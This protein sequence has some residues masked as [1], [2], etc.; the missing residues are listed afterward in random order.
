MSRPFFKSGIGDLEEAFDR[1]RND[2]EFLLKLIDELSHR[3][4]DRAARLKA[5]AVQALGTLRQFS[6][7][8]N[9]PEGQANAR[10]SAA[11]VLPEVPPL[12]AA[13]KIEHAAAVR[14]PMPPISNS[15]DAVLSA[16]TALEVLSPPSFRRP[17][18]L[19][20]GHKRA[21]AW[22]DGRRV[23]WE[24]N[25]EKARPRTRL[26][27]QI[28]LGTAK[29]EA[30]VARLMAV[31]GDTRIERHNAR[32]EAILALI[33]VD[34]EGRPIE[35]P[36]VALS[37]FGWAVP[38]ALAGD[39]DALGAW[40]AAEKPLVEGLDQLIRQ[41]DLNGDLRPL[42]AASIHNAY[43]WL[44]STL[45]LPADVVKPPAFAI[46]TYEY[47]RNPEPPEPLLLNSFFL[48]DLAM[49]AHH[50]RQDM[51]TANLRR[52]LGV[53]RPE[54]R[55][56]L[57]HDG[58]ALASAIRPILFS[59]A[60]WPG[61]RRHQLVLLQQAAVNLALQ[62]PQQSGILAV[63]GPPGTGKT[64][65]L[66]D[67]VA[68]LVTERARVM[69]GFDDPENAFTN[70][71]ERLRA[72]NAWIHL[73]K[74]DDRLRGFEILVASSNNK[75][76]ENVSAE[77]PG[78]SAIAEDATNLRYFTTLSDAL[79]EKETW[80]LI[81][82]V[83]GNATNRNHFKQTFW[84]HD[85][86][87]LWTY[88]A[89]AAGN[90]RTVEVTN[91]VTKE[92]TTRPPRIVTE[93]RAP[94]NHEDALRRWR[95]ARKSFTSALHR[96]EAALR[97]LESVRALAERLSGLAASEGQARDRL[98]AAVA[99]KAQATAL[100]RDAGQN[101]ASAR[102]RRDAAAADHKRHM[103]ERPGW[104]ARLFRTA[105]FRTWREADVAKYA[106]MQQ[107]TEAL[108]RA[109]TL[110]ADANK[111][112]EQAASA[113]AKAT[114]ELETASEQLSEAARVVGAAREKLGARFVDQAF[115]E[116]E[117]ADRH[118]LSPWLNPSAHRVRDDVFVAAIA[119]HKAFI[120]AAA[121]PLRHNLSALM[122]T[123]GGRVLSGA[124][125]EALLP[126]L[127]ASL[128]LVVPVVSTTFAAVER[129]LGRLPPE[130]LGWLLIDE[131]GQALP[132]AAVGALMRSKRAVVV[133]DP[134]QIEP[135]VEL[136]D[137]L[138]KTICRRFGVDPD[139][140]NAPEASVQTLADEAT[141]Y[142]AEFA[143]RY[144]SR[145]VGVPLLVHRR[146]AEPMFGISN[147]IAYE[148]LMVNAKEPALSA[149]REL[150]GPSRWFNIQG[151][152]EEKWC[153]Q[154][155]QLV[156]QLLQQM[157]QRGMNPDLY[158]ITPFRIVQDNLRKVIRDSGVLNGWTDD[159]W[160]WSTDRVG[161]VHV[162]QGREAEAVIFV[163][164]ASAPQQTRARDWAGK[165]PN[166]LNVAVTRAKEAFYIV[167]NR[168]LWCTAGVFRE[169]DARIPD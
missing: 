92:V 4:T 93:E 5:R 119:L 20:G 158:I 8:R 49:A 162:A 76:V 81:A 166:L 51:A 61:P 62:E 167:G 124:E 31:Y 25:G 142:V 56:D 165:R 26:Y 126:D 65:L 86:V 151:A 16:W 107:A 104:F 83:L 21:V 82:A 68:A 14:T 147:A 55:S 157:A 125:K 130:T 23:P 168:P 58:G 144:G 98:Q 60:R 87:G 109:T 34:R 39:L 13:P 28:V 73:S 112:L 46:Q 136:S 11:S 135:V 101:L 163:L 116:R 42:D 54:T 85:D 169:L 97:E 9:S 77:L 90:P 95:Q 41:E 145:T 103:T 115:F 110:A 102:H 111:H 149:V 6:D 22:L 134:L 57:L 1:E 74:V 118:Q 78:R 108:E 69:A 96:S 84:W 140:F 27:Y 48:K 40:E 129:M 120:D 155:G 24:G 18:D 105:R 154:E 88:L 123:F 59:P 133:G 33:I 91:P 152:A 161:T 89:A 64:T 150:I 35:A 122:D 70:S 17:E 71:G 7:Q 45:G 164:G 121:R 131:A 113:T 137:T 37:S 80:G 79:H 3:S 100:A 47:F 75:A 141:P 50:F 53:I 29:L 127:W 139:R 143:G 63:N 12:P 30:S 72:G 66:R 94:R 114:A 132:Q 67:I 156:V 128:F 117:H 36:A 52:Y 148:R 153:P 10:P 2:P 146:C 138:A 159:P 43:T 19:A 38:R 44:V 99:N 160:K 15:P 106:V 32:G